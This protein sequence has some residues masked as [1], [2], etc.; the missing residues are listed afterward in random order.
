MNNKNDYLEILNESEGFSET[1]TDSQLIY[2]G[3]IIHVYRDGITLPDGT[4]AVREVV[5]HIGAVCVVPVTDDGRVILVRQFRYPFGKMIYEIPAGK[6][7]SR[8]E[9]HSVAAMREL[10][11]ETGYTCKELEYIGDLYSTPG[12]CDEV[13]HMYCAR[14]LVKG[15]P[16]PDEDEFIDTVAIPMETVRD[17][18][19]DGD[20]A[21]SKTQAAVLKVYVKYFSKS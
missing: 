18:I 10:E 17:M 2:D 12:F 21:D 16:H 13:I 6:L 9:E 3:R 20:I 5:R 8:D 1:Q 7:D 11:E 14:G 4:G 15:A 19:L